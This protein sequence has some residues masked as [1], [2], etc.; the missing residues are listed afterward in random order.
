MWAA[1]SVWPWALSTARMAPP[2]DSRATPSSLTN[3]WLTARERCRV[4][5]P[6]EGKEGKKTKKERQKGNKGLKPGAATTLGSNRW[7]SLIWAGR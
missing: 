6:H 3:I 2:T 4:R 7:F 1:S 5:V